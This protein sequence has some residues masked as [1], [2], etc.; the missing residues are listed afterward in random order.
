M[1]WSGGVSSSR[2]VHLGLGSWTCLYLPIL[3]AL[4]QAAMGFI[5]MATAYME[6]V[7]WAS[8]ELLHMG[9]QDMVVKEE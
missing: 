1:T 6:W 8:M 2:Q 7:V 5:S 4:R 3:M 9:L